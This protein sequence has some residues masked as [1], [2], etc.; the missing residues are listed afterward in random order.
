VSGVK[1]HL[2]AVFSTHLSSDL[3]LVVN[4][5]GVVRE[6]KSTDEIFEEVKDFDH[7]VVPESSLAEALNARLEEARIGRFAGTPTQFSS[8]GYTLDRTELYIHLVRETS[9]SWRQAEFFLDHA[10]ESLEEEGSLKRLVSDSRFNQ[11]A[12]GNAI[13]QLKATDNI[14][15]ARQE[16]RL[17]GDVA[18]V[19]PE[20]LTHL[21]RKILPEEYTEIDAFS[22]GEYELNQFHVFQSSGGIARAIRENVDD[23]NQ[24]DTAVVV[25]SGSRYS[26]LI[27]NILKS[28]GLQ[29]ESA[30]GLEREERGFLMLCEVA[31]TDNRVR[32]RDVRPITRKLG[33]EISGKYLSEDQLE[34]IREFLNV[35]EYMSF[36]ELLEGYREVFS[37][38]KLGEKIQELGFHDRQISE[39]DLKILEKLLRQQRT[40]EGVVFI[41]PEESTFV[42]RS[43]V[44]FVGMDAEW[45]REN[46][47]SKGEHTAEDFLSLIQNGDSQY[48]MV[49]E[50]LNGEEVT[51]C[52]YLKQLFDVEGFTDHEFTRYQENRET[53]ESGERDGREWREIDTVSQKELN[54]FQQ[55]PKSYYFS[56]LVSGESE[57][58]QVKGNL[59]HQFAEYAFN[60]PEKL[61]DEEK[62]IDLMMEEIESFIESRERHRFR[63]EFEIG[64]KSVKKLVERTKIESFDHGL[65]EGSGENVFSEEFDGDVDSGFTE[66]YFRDRDLGA[67]GKID[68]MVSKDHILDIKTSSNVRNPR[69]IVERSLPFF[70]PERPDFQPALYILEMCELFGHRQ[71]EFTYFFTHGRLE[72]DLK[73]E[74]AFSEK[75]VTVKYRPW[76]FQEELQ[77]YEVFEHL[78]RDVKKDNDRRKTLEKLGVPEFQQFLADAEVDFR[79]SGKVEEELLPEFQRFA[80]QRIGDYRYVEKGCKSAL[81]K[82]VK[83]RKSSFYREDIQEFREFL[84]ESIEEI[85]E[86]RENGFPAGDKTG[87]EP[88]SEMIMDGAQP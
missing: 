53:P 88:F 8:R 1:K 45:Y 82:L 66:V 57:K 16:F 70:E 69:D 73:G 19:R 50:F 84:E 40:G 54:Y 64:V 36:G 55:S 43:Q 7:V 10:E 35:S 77:K 76:S 58:Q 79:D 20:K 78:I 75:K 5:F 24:D 15:T 49:Q 22:D 52:L 65:G 71:I 42:D 86:C 29:V 33:L 23:Q 11:G 4:Q 28:S 74:D 6:R 63:T 47:F 38:S 27:R 87:E 81:N 2:S 30:E 3:S 31:L 25:K 85:N 26:R 9:L 37:D 62:F 68:L 32:S 18:V 34:Q 72:K 51:P 41:D 17:E 21:D 61:E 83:Y 44:F 60:N 14:Y 59:I 13:E 39:T 48:F 56:Q 67:K 46:I 12:L 80:K